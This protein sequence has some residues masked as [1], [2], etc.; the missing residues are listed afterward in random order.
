MLVYIKFIQPNPNFCSILDNPPKKPRC[1]KATSPSTCDTP[2]IFLYNRDKTTPLLTVPISRPPTSS[3]FSRFTSRCVE[4][5]FK[6]V[7]EIH[8]FISDFIDKKSSGFFVCGLM[9]ECMNV[10]DV[11]KTMS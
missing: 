6:T 4:K 5:E 2:P 7:E 9:L 1:A 8:E 10:V 11:G 3:S